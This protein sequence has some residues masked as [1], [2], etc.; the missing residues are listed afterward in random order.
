M[1]FVECLNCI[2]DEDWEEALKHVNKAIEEEEL[3]VDFFVKRSFLFFRLKEFKLA[4]EDGKKAVE[5]DASVAMAWLRKGL[6][7]FELGL[8]EDARKSLETS[9]QSG[10]GDVRPGLV[11]R[12]QDYVA[13]CV[14]FCAKNVDMDW[15]QS[16]SHVTI[17]VMVAGLKQDQIKFDAGA[18]CV[19]LDIE[20]SRGELVSFNWDLF[21]AV[22]PD[23]C[24]ARVKP[25][26][27]EVRLKKANQGIH[28][29]SLER[30][31]GAET[32]MTL[33]PTAS[34]AAKDK[35]PSAYASGTNWDAIE[36][37]LENEDEPQG[38]E[39]LNK[40]FQDIYS[41]ATPETRRAM[42]KSFQ[43]SGGTVLSTNWNEV[44]E[45]DYESERVAPSGMEWK[46]WEGEKIQ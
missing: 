33:A 10:L 32:N 31:Q 5:I 38:E 29:P 26:R 15:Y 40:L 8:H 24:S 11:K 36:K 1:N 3:N 16:L 7:E 37:E 46:N 39:A 20:K 6:A 12:C 35:I 2:G 13:K 23:G 19:L 4:L 34:S 14:P 43:T 41:K 21:A 30:A 9:L 42:N 27:V 45:K 22:E 25:K 18:S 28:W 44:Q 17:D